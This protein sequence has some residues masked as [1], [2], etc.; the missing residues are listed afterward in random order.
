MHK[1]LTTIMILHHIFINLD[2]LFWYLFSTNIAIHRRL[3]KI[4]DNRFTWLECDFFNML[5]IFFIFGM[6]TQFLAKGFIW[7]EMLLHYI[8][9]HLEFLF[10]NLLVIGALIM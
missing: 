10:W 8:F 6:T 2:F 3:A 1:I 5:I 4:I 7:L 9:I